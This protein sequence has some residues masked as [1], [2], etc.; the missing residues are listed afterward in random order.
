MID[1]E[2]TILGQFMRYIHKVYRIGEH[3]HQIK[4]YRKRRSIKLSTCAYLLIFAF[5]FRVSSFNEI[6]FWIEERRTR[7]GHL[8]KKG[9]RLPK[10]DALRDIVK[11][12]QIEDV[13]N[14]FDSVIDKLAENKVLREN[15][16]NELRVAA[17]DG[18][19]VF[20]SR[21]KY[22]PDCLTRKVG[23]EEEYFHKAVACM[24]V[25]CDPHIILGM[26]MLKP[27]QDNSPKGEGEMTGVKRLLT[28]LRKRHYH[29][30][31]V[32]V[33]DA[34]YMNAPFI[35]LVKDIGMD[36]EN[37]GFRMLKTYFHADHGYIHGEGA[38]EK[39]LRLIMT[40]FKR[41]ELF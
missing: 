1:N 6:Q 31:D 35:N 22:C 30:S 19:E 3:V 4:D 39:V 28:D 23:E 13:Q 29:F 25:G 33:A 12:M 5:A 18:V 10:I 8:F 41:M 24:T 16:I 32:I 26:E 36:I 9:T 40:A 27:K 34:L 15:T 37:N 11:M 38:D 7:F 17:V 2:N 20:S 14:L 21:L